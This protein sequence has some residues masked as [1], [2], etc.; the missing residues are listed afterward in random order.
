MKE[1]QISGE[2]IKLDALLKFSG[3]CQTGG[4]AKNMIQSGFVYVN[5]EPCDMRGKKIKSG[6][7]ISF[8]DEDIKV[9]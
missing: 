1:I 4:E 2:F 8:N 5:N 6:D 9:T 7:I 3:L